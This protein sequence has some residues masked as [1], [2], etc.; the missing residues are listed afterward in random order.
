MRAAGLRT[1]LKELIGCIQKWNDPKKIKDKWVQKGRKKKK[2]EVASGQKDAKEKL[3]ETVR[4]YP[5][6]EV[7]GG[8]MV[9]VPWARQDL[10]TFTKGFRKLREAP[11]QWYTEVERMIKMSPVL[12]SD[13]NTFFDIVVLPDL[14]TEC[15]AAVA[16]PTEEPVRDKTTQ[17]PSLVVMEKYQQVLAHFKAKIPQKEIDWVK[18]SRVRQE[19]KETVYSFYERL[20]ENFRFHSGMQNVEK[21]EMAV[22]V[23]Y[24]VQGLR[25]EIRKG[26]E[27]NVVCWQTRPLDEL[28]RYPDY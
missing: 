18:I 4:M 24:F 15:K 5:L 2:D 7:Q 1:Q 10:M 9:H 23:S 8:G 19:S 20:M 27:Q 6:R 26:I 22:F 25:P 17:G 21:A 16:W 14:W 12:W 11:G 28:L 13:L 3:I